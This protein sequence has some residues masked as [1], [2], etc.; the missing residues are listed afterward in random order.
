[1]KSALSG[2]PWWRGAK[3]AGRVDG[4]GKTEVL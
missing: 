3:A 1:V 4:D 2:S